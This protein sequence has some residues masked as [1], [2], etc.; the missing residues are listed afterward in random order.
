MN[1]KNA[2]QILP[3][4]KQKCIKNFNENTKNKKRKM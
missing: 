2:P 4:I 3:K 1:F